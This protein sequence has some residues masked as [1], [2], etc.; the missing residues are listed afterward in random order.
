MRR[1]SGSI[2]LKAAIDAVVDIVTLGDVAKRIL[3]EQEFR[4]QELGKYVTG[5]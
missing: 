2:Y 3:S 5:G 1:R 4:I